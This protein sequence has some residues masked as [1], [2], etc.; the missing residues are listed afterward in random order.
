MCF[1]PPP[2]GFLMPP[3]PGGPPPGMMPPGMPGMPPFQPGARPP[4]PPPPFGHPGMPGFSPPPGMTP[5]I[6][7][8]SMSPPPPPTF[9]PAAST[10][11]STSTASVQSA[12]LEL[13]L[14]DPSLAQT[15]PPFKKATDL[16]WSDP[17]FSPVNPLSLRTIW[18]L[19]YGLCLGGETC[20]FG[21]VPCP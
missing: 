14:P 13:K 9:V 5:P 17:N 3:F 6:P 8:A 10:N 12:P 20:Y 16:K 21:Q 1:S 4:F 19:T 7:S 11:I 18:S 15:N 2:P